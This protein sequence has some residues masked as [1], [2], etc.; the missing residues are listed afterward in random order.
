VTILLNNVET[1]TVDRL[2][3]PLQ[4]SLTPE[5][6]QRIVSRRADPAVQ[7]RPEWQAARHSQGVLTAEE[8][9]EYSALVH[10]GALI[11]LLQAKA[12]KVSQGRRC[13]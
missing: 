5:V 12:R 6:A 2:L 4:A 7:A 1:Q 9:A 10:A 8:A 11:S 13:E 3:D